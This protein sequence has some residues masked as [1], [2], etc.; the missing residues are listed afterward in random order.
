MTE[1]QTKKKRLYF[2][3]CTWVIYESNF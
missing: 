1:T 3:L 2:Q